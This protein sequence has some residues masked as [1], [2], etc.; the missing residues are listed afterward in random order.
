MKKNWEFLSILKSYNEFC[1]GKFL[2]MWIKIT[3]VRAVVLSTLM[4]DSHCI[5]KCS[6]ISGEQVIKMLG[7]LKLT[8]RILILK[9]IL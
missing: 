9:L 1:V 2:P 4:D 3:Q 7:N 8:G 5:I 6:K